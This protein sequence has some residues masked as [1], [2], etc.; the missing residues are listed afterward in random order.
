MTDITLYRQG[1][2]GRITL[3]RPDHLNALTHEMVIGIGAA[4][5]AWARDDAI[6]LVLIDAEGPRAFCAGGD[7][8]SMYRLAAAGNLAAARQ[9]WADEYRLNALIAAFPKPYV[10]FC[11]GFTM[12]GGVGVALHGSHRILGESSRIGMPECAVGLVPDAGGSW[13]LAGA[14]GRLGEY[15]GLTGTRMGP[16]DAI[17]AGFADHFVPET[18]WEALKIALAET[19]RAAIVADFARTPPPAPLAEAEAAID[20]LFAAATT[21]EILAGLG[22]D[23]LSRAARAAI[24]TGAPLSLA[25]TPELIR[26]ARAGAGLWPALVQEYRFAWRCIPEGD[27]IEGIRA[28]II[29]RD[30]TPRWKHGRVEQVAPAEIDAMLAPLAPQDELAPEDLP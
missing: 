17:H 11:H 14:P 25:C 28:A 1:R 16:G 9:F 7:L 8:R 27:F 2:A 12:G 15:L 4:L 5:T 21:A 30:G 10:A 22:D 18:N 24:G 19:G 13:L 20:A 23:D 6:D 29:D 26:R 3:R